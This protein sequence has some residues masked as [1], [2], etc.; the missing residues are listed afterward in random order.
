MKDRAATLPQLFEAD[1]REGAISFGAALKEVDGNL[2]EGDGDDTVLRFFDLVHGG[3]WL[4][5]VLAER[6]GVD[7]VDI[8][9]IDHLKN[10]L[11]QIP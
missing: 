6:A 5:L 8:K 10:A 7:P 1:I 11:A 9:N 2:V 4:S 3:D